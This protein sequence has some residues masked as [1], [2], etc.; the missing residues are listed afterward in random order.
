MSERD[1]PITP[2]EQESIRLSKLID[3]YKHTEG[4]EAV[5]EARDRIYRKFFTASTT[6][7]HYEIDTLELDEMINIEVLKATAA[8]DNPKNLSY[9]DIRYMI[10]SGIVHEWNKRSKSVEKNIVMAG[11]AIMHSFNIW[12][13]SQLNGVSEIHLDEPTS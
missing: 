8:L 10:E 5:L 2:E 6:D 13:A 9:D 7:H 12:S 4:W 3:T 11:R 1:N